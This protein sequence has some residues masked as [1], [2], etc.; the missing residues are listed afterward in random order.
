MAGLWSFTKKVH[1]LLKVALCALLTFHMMKLIIGCIGIG[2]MLMMVFPFPCD[3][4]GL[5]DLNG[6]IVIPDSRR[7]WYLVVHE[8]THWIPGNEGRAQEG[9]IGGL[10]WEEGKMGRYTSLEAGRGEPFSWSYQWTSLFGEV[11][12]IEVAFI[13]D[14]VAGGVVCGGGEKVSDKEEDDEDAEANE[15]LSLKIAE[16]AMLQA[17]SNV[18]DEEEAEI[19][20]N[21]KEVSGGIDKGFESFCSDMFPED[22]VKEKENVDATEAMNIGDCTAEKNPA[23]VSDNAV[24]RRLL[25]RGEHAIIVVKRVTLQLTE[26]QLDVR[27]HVLF[28]GVSNI[29]LNSAQRLVKKIAY[30]SIG[31]CDLILLVLSCLLVFSSSVKLVKQ[32]LPCL[33]SLIL[34]RRG[35]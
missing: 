24:L 22:K 20:T 19:L 29:M 26:L 2:R 21:V 25:M 12:G 13:A 18:I 32:N 6:L 7:E 1:C 15:D 33:Y 17:C 10:G 4:G 8:M 23:E 3:C 11:L 9:N 27:S 16:K 34:L 14:E 31:I 28:V 30:S 5:G 35:E